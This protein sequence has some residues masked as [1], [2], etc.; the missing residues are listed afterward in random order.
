MA[1]KIYSDFKLLG[2]SS[3]FGKLCRK[4]LSSTSEIDTLIEIGTQLADDFL[5][6]CVAMEY[7]QKKILFSYIEDVLQS[8]VENEVYV[9]L[10]EGFFNR[11]A[12]VLLESTY[13]TYWHPK[14]F[15]TLMGNKSREKMVFWFEVHDKT[16]KLFLVEFDGF[17]LEDKYKILENIVDF[18]FP[19]FR[20]F[21]WDNFFTWDDDTYKQLIYQYLT[22]LA[23]YSVLYW[24]S[25]YV[26]NLKLFIEYSSFFRENSAKYEIYKDI[27]IAMMT[28]FIE[29]LFFKIHEGN[30]TEKGEKIRKSS[31]RRILDNH[32][33]SYIESYMKNYHGDTDFW[34]D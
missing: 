21:Y 25:L 23:S 1:L 18:C 26:N 11:L 15:I 28:G 17:F 10:D 9:C 27:D 22:N 32:S 34:E 31:L 2:L 6:H 33:I 19:K 5:E 20:G 14:N 3:V 7:H 30:K 16:P 13:S 12:Q 24:D 29:D 8:R 4:H